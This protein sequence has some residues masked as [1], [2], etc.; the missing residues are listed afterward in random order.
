MYGQQVVGPA[1]GL[2]QLLEPAVGELL[3]AVG[4]ERLQAL[5]LLALGL[6]VD[7]QDVLDLERPPRRTC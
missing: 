4:L 2:A 5:D 6:R 1:R 7:A 3:V